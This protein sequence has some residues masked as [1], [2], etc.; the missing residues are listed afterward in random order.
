MIYRNDM[1]VA[2][3]TGGRGRETKF[4]LPLTPIPSS[5]TFDFLSNLSIL[6]LGN[7]FEV[8]LFVNEES[9]NLKISASKEKQDDTRAKRIPK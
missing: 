7:G 2:K 9:A 8:V 3:K 4:L 5:K 6:F 1:D